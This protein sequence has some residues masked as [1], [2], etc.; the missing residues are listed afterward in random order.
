MLAARPELAELHP[1]QDEDTLQGVLEIIH[2]FDLILRELS[3]M[4]QFVFQAG[5]GADAAYTHAC[6]TRAY[7]AARGELEQR[8][9]VITTIQAHPCNA[10][11]AAAAGFKVVT[12]P[13]E[14]DG[15]PSLDA[16]EAAVSDRTAALMVNNPDDM[17]I[18]NPD[19]KRWVE[20]VHDAG[21]LVLLRPRQLQRRDEQAARARARLRRL[22]VHAAQDLRRAEGR[23]RPGGRRL[24]LQRG[25]RAVPAA[26]AR[27]P[28]WRRAIGSTTTRPH[29]VGRVREFWGNVPQVVKAYAWA[30]AMGAEGIAEAS[31]LSVLANN[32]ME[33][34]LLAIRGVTQSHP[35]CRQRRGWR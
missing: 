30:R 28:R 27:A 9:E 15:Y 19:I 18:Y 13:L 21:G 33:Q 34:R 23:R 7:H 35:A 1:D 16:L 32:Y 6:V 8:D 29:S 2:G 26:A 20:I 17:G 12:L 14:E 25:A 11:T 31:D 5:G 24:R 22:H 3:G 10:A 4:D